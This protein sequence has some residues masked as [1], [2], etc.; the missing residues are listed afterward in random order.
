MPKPQARK[1]LLAKDFALD[2]WAVRSEESEISSGIFSREGYAFSKN[3][4][5]LYLKAN[6]G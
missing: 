6:R 5:M 2:A 4:G 3:A 1:D